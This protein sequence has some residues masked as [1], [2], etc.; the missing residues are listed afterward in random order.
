VKADTLLEDEIDYL[1]FKVF[2]IEAKASSCI[3]RRTRHR[4]GSYYGS[5]YSRTVRVWRLK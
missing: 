2:W 3:S 5:K 1:K 4:D